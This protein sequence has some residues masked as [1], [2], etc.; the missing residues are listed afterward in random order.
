[1]KG[2]RTK[3]TL[4]CR[5]RSRLTAYSLKRL[6]A[7]SRVTFVPVWFANSCGVTC[8]CRLAS[9]Y[10]LHQFMI[11]LRSLRSSALWMQAARTLLRSLRLICRSMAIL[12]HSPDSSSTPPLQRVKRSSLERTNTY[13]ESMSISRV[14]ARPLRVAACWRLLFIC[15][16]SAACPHRNRHRRSLAAPT[17]FI[18]PALAVYCGSVRCHREQAFSCRV[19]AL[20]VPFRLTAR[21]GGGLCRRGMLFQLSIRQTKKAHLSVSLS[22]YIDGAAPGVEPR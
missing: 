12:G 11:S 19:H 5:T 21:R 13:S 17:D 20:S 1:M 3:R 22:R 18:R 6:F 2:R 10:R 8:S 4:V 16:E 7:L 14:S 9:R 15:N